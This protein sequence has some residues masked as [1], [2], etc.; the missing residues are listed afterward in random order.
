MSRPPHSPRLYNS[1]YTWRRVQIMKL[2]IMQLSPPSRHSIPLWRSETR[3]YKL[4]SRCW[5]VIGIWLHNMLP[6]TLGPA[7]RCGFSSL[8]HYQLVSQ[9]IL[10]VLIL[11]YIYLHVQCLSEIVVNYVINLIILVLS[12]FRVSLFA[13]NHLTIRYNPVW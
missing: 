11:L 13:A 12:K 1:N 6:L 9:E 2:L 5:Y 8:N 10:C 7:D 3:Q 4:I